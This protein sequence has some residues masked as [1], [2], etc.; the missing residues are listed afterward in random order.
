MMV[1]VHP[2]LNC[3]FTSGCSRT[4]NCTGTKCSRMRA[5]TSLCGYVT[6]SMVWQPPQLGLN[7]SIKT[8]FSSARASCRA[9]SN[10]LRQA[11]LDI[12]TPPLGLMKDAYDG[13][14]SSRWA[15]GTFV[16]DQHAPCTRPGV[17]E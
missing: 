10:E 6:V 15:V 5:C 13:Q 3:R 14:M 1:G 11:M 7:R 9:S 16:G 2:L 8:S 12:R 17:R 4:L